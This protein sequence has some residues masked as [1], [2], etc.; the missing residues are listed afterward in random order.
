MGERRMSGEQLLKKLRAKKI[1]RTR[2]WL[3]ALQ[4]GGIENLSVPLCLALRDILGLNPTELTEDPAM[5]GNDFL[6]EATPM[7]RWV[8]QHWDM[9]PKDLQDVLRGQIEAY[10]E[11][12]AAQP[13]LDQ[14]IRGKDAKIVPFDPRAKK[15]Q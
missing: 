10:L 7:A 12:R 6:P 14:I 4:N 15:G 11:L 13:A 1:E 3:I 2:T 5:L 9:L 8:G